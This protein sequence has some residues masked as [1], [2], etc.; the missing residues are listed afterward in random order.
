MITDVELGIGSYEQVPYTNL[1]LN[2]AALNALTVV[3]TNIA[4]VGLQRNITASSPFP[5]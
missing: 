2:T 5:E 1:N 4:T 3:Y